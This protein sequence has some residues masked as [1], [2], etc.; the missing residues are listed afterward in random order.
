MVMTTLNQLAVFEPTATAM[1]PY[2]W[3]QAAQGTH[4]L[5]AIDMDVA[6]RRPMLVVEGRERIVRC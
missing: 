6:G 3:L 4:S 5:K 1:T 2:K